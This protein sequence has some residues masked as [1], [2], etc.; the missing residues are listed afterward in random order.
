MRVAF[1]LAAVALTL[2][3]PASA[4]SVTYSV[5]HSNISSVTVNYSARTI[6]WNYSDGTQ[7]TQAEGAGVDFEA[8]VSYIESQYN[9]VTEPD[10]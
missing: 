7:Y 6:T 2:A 4:L 9:R 3:T 10:K 8:A 5:D 1:A